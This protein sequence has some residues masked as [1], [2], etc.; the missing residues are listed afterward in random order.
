MALITGA[1][2]DIEGRPLSGWRLKVRP[3]TADVSE[4]GARTVVPSEVELTLDA[5]GRFAVDLEPSQSLT[6]PVPYLFLF[7]DPTSGQRFPAIRWIPDTDRDFEDLGEIPVYAQGASGSIEPDMLDFGGAAPQNGMVIVVQD[8][9]FGQQPLPAGGGGGGG[10]R[11]STGLQDMP[12]SLSG[13]AGKVLTV[14]TLGNVYVLDEKPDTFAQ[15]ADTPNS[16]AGRAG[17]LVRVSSGEDELELDQ[18]VDADIPNSIARD[19]EIQPWA[20][21]GDNT[22]IPAGKLSNAPSGGAGLNQAA[23]D[24]RVRAGVADWA[25]AGNTDKLPAGKLPPVPDSLIPSGIARDAEVDDWAKTANPAAKIPSAK[26]PAQAIAAGSVDTLELADGSVTVAKLDDNTP[27]KQKAFRDAI[28]APSVDEILRHID[29]VYDGSFTGA[30]GTGGD[31]SSTPD[32]LLEP[33]TVGGNAGT[34]KGFHQDGSDHD[35]TFTINGNDATFLTVLEGHALDINGHRFLFNHYKLRN[36]T[37]GTP[38]IEYVWDAPAGVINVGANSVSIY[39]PVDSQNFLPGGGRP[40]DMV[41]YLA[42]GTPAIVRVA[43]YVDAAVDHRP[44][45]IMDEHAFAVN[46]GDWRTA[47]VGELQ[48]FSPSQ[49][50]GRLTTDRFE[51]EARLSNVTGTATQVHL[52]GE[53]DSPVYRAVPG[54]TLAGLTAYTSSTA[55]GYRL[56][57]WHFYEGTTLGGTADLYI[58]ITGGFVAGLFLDWLPSG[59]S[60]LVSRALVAQVTATVWLQATR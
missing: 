13:Q 16:Y 29:T 45:T 14:D 52:D 31:V 49:T 6:P 24:A 9:R 58:A 37:P 18:L 11:R 28:G 17:H 60:G 21:T 44:Q 7:Q 4:G 53:D 59:E 57:R 22:P 39:E 19:A 40:G 27:A 10:V 42:G 41:G 23:V 3:L 43:D 26:L 33:F 50:V 5:N 38:P 12:H 54:K 25:E 1:M 51:I 36:Y 35:V 34:I 8:G 55:N 30:A 46:R 20:R 15:L 32:N 56:A 47:Q 48:T 2:T